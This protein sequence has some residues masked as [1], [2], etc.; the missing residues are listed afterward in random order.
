MKVVYDKFSSSTLL[1]YLKL[2]KKQS[3]DKTTPKNIFA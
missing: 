1:L 2:A 3:I